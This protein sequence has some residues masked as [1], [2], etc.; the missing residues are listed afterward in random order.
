MSFAVVTG[1]RAAGSGQWPANLFSFPFILRRMR[2]NKALV[3]Q[4]YKRDTW[5]CTLVSL[6]T[7]S[8]C[9]EFVSCLKYVSLIA[10][11]LVA[12]A[13]RLV[14]LFFQV[15]EVGSAGTSVYGSYRRRRTNASSILYP[16]NKKHVNAFLYLIIKRVSSI[17][18]FTASQY[19]STSSQFKHAH[20]HIPYAYTHKYT[21]HTTI[22][23]IN[24]GFL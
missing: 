18:Y 14:A 9:R 8:L 15:E 4:P 1:T 17:D 13:L 3:H 12:A 20:A 21:M 10:F 6:F 23:T 2:K 11:L 24:T 5:C 22:N 7:W 16:S 19:F